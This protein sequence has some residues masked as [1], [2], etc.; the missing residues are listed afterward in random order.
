MSST[1]HLHTE[2]EI[3]N[4]SNHHTLLISQFFKISSYRPHHPKIFYD[5]HPKPPRQVR[6]SVL[7]AFKVD[8][9]SV[10]TNLNHSLNPNNLEVSTFVFNHH[11][12]LLEHNHRNLVTKFLAEITPS[13]VICIPPPK[14]KP[15]KKSLLRTT[16]YKLS[17]VRSGYSRLL[18]TYLSRLDNKVSPLCPYCHLAP[19]SICHILTAQRIPP[20][21]LPQTCGLGL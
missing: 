21:S 8:I 5:S 9:D 10:S 3:L 2:V 7:S 6:Q 1:A 14:V 19:H 20:H 15:T 16:R 4:V 11:K 18:K 12:S 17:Q 13:K